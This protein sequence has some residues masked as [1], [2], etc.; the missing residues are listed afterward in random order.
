M[1]G[2]MS[3]HLLCL[4]QPTLGLDRL[5]VDSTRVAAHG[6]RQPIRCETKSLRDKFPRNRL[7]P[8][9]LKRLTGIAR[10]PRT[11]LTALSELRVC[12]EVRGAGVKRKSSATKSMALL[13]AVVRRTKD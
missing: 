11:R 8:M 7:T 2:R 3:A 5:S 10:L 6:A 9:P 13:S 4:P 1:N 12:R